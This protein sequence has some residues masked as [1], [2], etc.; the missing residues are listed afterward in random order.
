MDAT[1]R[2]VFNNALGAFLEPL[3]K[4]D[5]AV[6]VADGVTVRG[7]RIKPAAINLLLEQHGVDARV[8][9]GQ[10]GSL[11]LAYNAIPGTV[12]LQMDKVDIR[13]RPHAMKTVGKALLKGITELVTKPQCLDNQMLYTNPTLVGPHPVYYYPHGPGP[14]RRVVDHP[15][16]CRCSPQPMEP[17]P[18]WLNGPRYDPYYPSESY[19]QPCHDPQCPGCRWEQRTMYKAASMNRPIQRVCYDSNCPECRKERRHRKEAR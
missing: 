19:Q 3:H 18:V 7:L 13:V 17:T 8:I 16:G 15:P 11:R 2:S 9:G 10:V 12:S 4:G 14:R 5:V 1:L 6:S